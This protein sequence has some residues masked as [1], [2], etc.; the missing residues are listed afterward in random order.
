MAGPEEIIISKDVYQT[1]E[2]L[3]SIEPLPPR[4]TMQRTESWENFRLLH[5]TE[6]KDGG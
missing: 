5:I 2:N 1:I 4:E 6:R 3:V